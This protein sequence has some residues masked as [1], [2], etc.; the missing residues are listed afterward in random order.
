MGEFTSSLL[1]RILDFTH[2]DPVLHHLTSTHDLREAAVYMGQQVGVVD[3][4]FRLIT[5]VIW[6][7]SFTVHG[8]RH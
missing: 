2:S 4:R 7:L 8:S 3:G 6:Y 5:R 1:R